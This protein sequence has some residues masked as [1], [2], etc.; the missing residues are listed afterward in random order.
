MYRINSYFSLV[1]RWP[2][3]K[4]GWFCRSLRFNGITEGTL[5][6]YEEEAWIRSGYQPAASLVDGAAQV[7]T[8]P[9]TITGRL[10]KEY[11][12]GDGCEKVLKPVGGCARGLLRGISEKDWS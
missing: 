10:K 11:W 9:A 4:V 6:V 7:A 1:H 8:L 5:E 2:S 12:Y 3:Y